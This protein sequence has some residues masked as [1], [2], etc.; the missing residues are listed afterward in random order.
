MP[1]SKDS[2]CKGPEVG[3]SMASSS[4]RE[5]DPATGIEWVGGLGGCKVPSGS[6]RV[7]YIGM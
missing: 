6:L 7:T 3:M 5:K 2:M 1:G 4:L